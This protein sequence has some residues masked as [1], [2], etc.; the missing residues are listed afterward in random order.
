MQQFA[1][2][3]HELEKIAEDSKEAFNS[4]ATS[5]EKPRIRSHIC[6]GNNFTECLASERKELTDKDLRE[7]EPSKKTAER[8]MKLKSQSQRDPQHRTL[9]GG[10]V[11]LKKHCF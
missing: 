3:V 2:E 11:Y 5:S 1:H 8:K 10:L 6:K 7:V 9:Q 4:L